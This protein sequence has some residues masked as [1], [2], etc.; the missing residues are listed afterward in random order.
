WGNGPVRVAQKE[1]PGWLFAA[2]EL[3]MAPS[4]LA[5][6]DISLMTRSLLK[7]A[8]YDAFYAPIKLTSGRDSHYSLGLRVRDDHG[9]LMLGHDGGG[10]GFLSANIMWPAQK[11][12]VAAFTNS[13]W[14]S[15]DDVAARVAFV[16]LPPTTAE[17]RA[18]T[19][20]HDFQAGKIDRKLFTENGNAYLTASVLADQ[21]T[22]LAPLGPPRLFQLE[23]EQARGGFNTRTWKITTAKGVLTAVERAYPDGK[24]EQF[25]ISKGD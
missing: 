19:V 8:S 16:V 5:R 15:P 3:A 10:S 21:K 20:F 18:R 1:G 2:G 24:L 11:V 9:R 17:A 13:D 6:W 4:E 7:P 23:G 22:G 25:M 12:A 14:A